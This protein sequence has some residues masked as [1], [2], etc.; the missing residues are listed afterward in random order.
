MHNGE[1]WELARCVARDGIEL[2][3][4]NGFLHLSA[5][6]TKEGKPRQT[7]IPPNVAAWLEGYLPTPTHICPDDYPGYR[8]IRRH[9]AIP[10]DG[11]RHTAI[12][13]YVAKNGSLAGAATEFGCSEGI[14]RNHYFARMGPKVAEAF[15]QI[16]PVKSAF[17]MPGLE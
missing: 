9:F 17:A 4:Q 3:F 1:I 11:L 5:E 16:I 7:A 2:Y 12:S 6:I 13:A 15:Y 14:I 10:P 8:K